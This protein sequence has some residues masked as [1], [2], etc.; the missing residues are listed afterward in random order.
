[1]ACQPRLLKTLVIS[2]PF[3][4]EEYHPEETK[5]DFQIVSSI[6]EWRSDYHVQKCNSAVSQVLVNHTKSII[7]LSYLKLY[8]SSNCLGRN[9]IIVCFSTG[10]KIMCSENL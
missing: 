9:P 5:D 2:P 8:T 10:I 1:M 6:P 7:N 4:K 3:H